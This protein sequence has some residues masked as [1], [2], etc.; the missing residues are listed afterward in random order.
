MKYAFGLLHSPAVGP[1]TWEP[2][3]ADLQAIGASA[4]V[5][6]MR[7]VSDADPPYWQEVV[8]RACD[9][10]R[11]LPAD[12]PLVLCAHS[13]AGL[14]MPQIWDRLDRP[15]AAFIFV[16]ASVPP[17]RG[18][19]EMVPR[20]LLAHLRLKATKGRLPPWTD[21]F[22]EQDVAALFPMNGLDV[23]WATNS[24]ACHWPITKEPFQCRMG[25]PRYRLGTL[26]LVRHTIRSLSRRDDV[27]GS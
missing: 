9:G 5:P 12:E 26:S 23:A 17:D 25:G 13:N 18:V 16:D 15:V 10:L 3:A 14:F 21:W 4:A 20:A 2:V 7:S 27:A 22:E 8:A 24:D 6:D 19:A 11:D 1:A